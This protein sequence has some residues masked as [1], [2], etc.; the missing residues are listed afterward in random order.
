MKMGGA[1][2]ISKIDY[3]CIYPCM[4]GLSLISGWFAFSLLHTV[5]RP[6]PPALCLLHSPMPLSPTASFSDSV[7]E[8]QTLILSF[9]PIIALET[10]EEERVQNLLQA[11]TKDMGLQLFE[12]S[13][14]TGLGRPA[15]S[16]H[17]R[18]HNDYAPAGSQAATPFENSTEPL[19]ALQAIRE[20]RLKA[21]FWLKDFA[22]HLE[23]ATIARQ[24]R[25][26]GQLFSQSP[27]ALVISGSVITLPKEISHDAVYFD[28]KLP[29]RDELRQTIMELTGSLK[30]KNNIRVELAEADI[31]Q[32]A[33]VLSGM[34]LK[35]ARQA[36]AYAALEDGYLNADDVQRIVQR[37]IQIIR[38]QGLIEYLPIQADSPELG[39][40]QGL[41][42]WLARAKI[43][44]SP[45]A[46]ALNLS[47]PKGVLIVG[48][49]GCGKSLAAK[50]IAHE[51]QMPLLKLEAGRIYDKYVGESEKNFRQAIAIAESMAPTVLWIDEIEKAMGSSSDAD[52]GLSRRLFG[53]FLTW[54]QEKSQQVFVVATA[55]DLLPLP[56]ELLRKGRFDEIFFVDLPD[57]QERWAILEI[58]LSRRQQVY[59]HLDL[60][61]LVQATEGFSGAE[62]EQVVIASLYQAL[63]LSRPLDTATILET[64]RAT[65]P[66]SVTRREDL[67]HLR[68]IA[69]GRFVSVR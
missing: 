28:L 14:T 13:L 49:Q 39:G 52:G 15:A 33:L 55:N 32:L 23:D 37:K 41:K 1:T 4:D 12:W 62:I 9:H 65:I 59:Q 5:C 2:K 51:W 34:T 26:V 29:G 31:E 56:P 42:Q 30:T 58:H 11:V 43:G 48:M 69:G 8:L 24:F 63:Y 44:F 46:K 7:K 18:W 67:D 61:V 36:I 6:L 57:P 66:L 3:P 47:P 25:E 21:V 60:A 45:A 35:Q 19:Q 68:A 17:N 53:A 16:S 20:Q 54:M 64:I 27:S 10:P 50:A 22:R 38:E 40:F